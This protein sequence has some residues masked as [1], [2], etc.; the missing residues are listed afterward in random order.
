MGRKEGGHRWARVDD[1]KGFLEARGRIVRGEHRPKTI[2]GISWPVCSRCGLL[3]LR[4]EVTR[5]AINQECV[6]E[7]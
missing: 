1:V 6:T 2:R 7:E 5:R 4:N 3:Y